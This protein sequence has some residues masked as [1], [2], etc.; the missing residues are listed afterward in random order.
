MALDVVVLLERPI[1]DPVAVTWLA[2]AVDD[3]AV[4]AA[5][6]VARPPATAPPEAEPRGW[7]TTLPA[8]DGIEL[9]VG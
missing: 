3:P 4:F 7:T 2:V 6:L 9:A 1:G 8:L 5:T